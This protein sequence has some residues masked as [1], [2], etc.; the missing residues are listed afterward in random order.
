MRRMI[1]GVKLYRVTFPM[2]FGIMLVVLPHLHCVTDSSTSMQPGAPAAGA[3]LEPIRLS[4][5]G[6]R[7]VRGQSGA[8]FVAWGCNYDHDESGRLLEDYWEE[9]WP[10]VVEDFKEMKALGANVVRIHLQIA[11]F[12]KAPDEP[13]EAALKQLARLVAL[14][15]ETGLYLNIT[16][17]AC[18]HKRDVPKWYDALDEGKRWDVQGLFWEAIAKTCSQS[19]AVFCYDLMNEPILPGA[20]KRETEW[21]A[22][23][24]GGKHFVQRIT[25]DLAGRTRKQVAKAWVDK[26]VAAIRKHDNRHMITVGVIPWVHT[27]PKAKPL[28][29][30]KEV[31]GNLDFVSVHF[32]PKKGEVDKALKALAAYDIG[33]PLVVEEMFPLKCGVEELDVFIDGSRKIAEGW[34][35]FY[36]G[37]GIDEYTEDDG[38]AGAIKKRWLEYFRAKT[39]EILGLGNRERRRRNTD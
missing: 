39:P 12:M 13:D 30:S 16:G 31:G 9:K 4:K 21:L 27:W 5:D 14:A 25:L 32:Y 6:A 20:K 26:L 15:E 35:G 33:K 28:F 7:F 36:W 19:D 8:E 17:L 22:G 10:T 11:K 37:K 29:Y 18:Y 1:T 38:M 23:E 3:A 24:F 34:I 2:V